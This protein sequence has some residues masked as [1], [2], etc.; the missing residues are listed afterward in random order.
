MAQTF[1]VTGV[2]R[3][4][5]AE[6]ARQ[7][8]AR[9]DRVVGTVRDAAAPPRTGF[10]GPL[11]SLE[12]TEAPSIAR[13][14][15]AVGDV[16]IDVLINSAGASCDAKSLDRCR[17]DEMTRVFT[18]NSFAPVLVTRALAGH[19]RRGSRRV[20]VNI[21]SVMGSMARNTGG[22]SYVYR[23]SKAALN[24]LTVCMHHELKSEGFICVALHPGWVRTDM[25]GPSAPVT[26]EQSVSGMLALIDRLRPEDSGG[27]FAFDGERLPW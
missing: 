7:V 14:G 4:I 16:A 3:G 13:L 19:L 24:M 15:D 5:G 22:S 8:Q 9:G 6:F 10:S 17:M 25:G 27:Y 18:V 11:V 2:G 23:A 1:L 12:L 20:V 21:S 26:P